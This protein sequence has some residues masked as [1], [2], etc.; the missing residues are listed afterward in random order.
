MR[1]PRCHEHQEEQL[2]LY[3]RYQTAHERAFERYSNELRKPR[4]QNRKVEIGF[5]SQKGKA[6]AEP[7][8]EAGE[9]RRQEL[10]Q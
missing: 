8:Q 9:N 2:A 5:E 10:H 6:A 7:R 4:N 3:L 1:N